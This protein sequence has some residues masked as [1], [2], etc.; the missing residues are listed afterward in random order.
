MR[1][2]GFFRRYPLVAVALVVLAVTL[3]LLLFG[4][5]AIAQVVATSMVLIVVAITTWDMIKDILKGHLGLD[6]LAVV[7]MVST[8]LVGEYVA[9]LIIVLMLTGGEALEDYAAN[10]AGKEL[11][12]LISRAPAFANRIEPDGEITRIKVG[13]VLVGDELI[14]RPSELVPVDGVLADEVASIDESSLTGEPLPVEKF[15]EDEVFSGTVNGTLAFTMKATATAEDSQYASIVKL[16]TEAVESKAPMVR[17]ADRYAVPFTIAALAIAAIAWIVTGDPV[18][19][20][21]VL[22]VATPCPLLIAAPVA[23]MGGMSRAAKAGVIVKNGG[24]L[25]SMAQAKSAAFDKTGTLTRGRAEVRRVVPAADDE[26]TILGLAAAAEQYSVHVFAHAIV[27]HAKAAGILFPSIEKAEETATLGVRAVLPGGTSIRVG[28]P[29][30][31]TE[32]T[33]RVEAPTLEPGETAVYVSRDNLLSGVIIVADPLRKESAAT[34]AVLERL[35]VSHRIMVT[36]DVPATAHAIASAVGITEVFPECTPASKVT[37]VADLPSRPVLMIG[38][39]INDAPVLAAAEVG[40]AM[41]ARGATAAS[42]SAAAV[43]TKDDLFV[44][45][46]VVDISQRTVRVA[47]ESIWLGILISVGL[48]FVA[49]FGYLPAIVGALL[50]EVVDLVAILGALRALGGRTLEVPAI[51]P[52]AQRQAVGARG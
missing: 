14:V 3:S 38:D 13:E 35:G 44:V 7:A 22:V 29:S 2:V 46:R 49:A 23:F 19:F 25:E 26:E 17:L 47:L 52:A 40:I 50:Q 6:I 41:G 9:G 4:Q 42:E 27:D 32:V 34:L 12:A 1:I 11:D 37:I 45:A 24:A 10:R 21:E 5:P 30:Y 48:M 20:A 28:K 39:G 8:V 43:I 15:R 36:G 31:I 18:R 51:E 16:V 33:G